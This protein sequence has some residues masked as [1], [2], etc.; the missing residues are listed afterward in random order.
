[1]GELSSLM[2]RLL[3]TTSQAETNVESE[4]VLLVFRLWRFM[5]A[6]ARS[7]SRLVHLSLMLLF[8]L[9]HLGFLLV[10][11]A[12]RFPQAILSIYNCVKQCRPGTP[13]QVGDSILHRG[14]LLGAGDPILSLSV[15]N[16]MFINRRGFRVRTLP[17][18]PHQNL[19]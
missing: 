5:T 17:H 1:M 12:W 11:L 10:A 7:G 2:L 15:H 19:M 8:R 13:R 3:M 14:K 18:L 4:L 9:K 6:L 16:A